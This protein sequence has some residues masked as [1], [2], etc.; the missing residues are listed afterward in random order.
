MNDV[1]DGACDTVEGVSGDI[2][3]DEPLDLLR[4]STPGDS[5][6]NIS[7]QVKEADV[8][9]SPDVMIIAVVNPKKDYEKLDA[10]NIIKNLELDV[11]N[12]NKL[13][14]ERDLKLKEL[15]R[16]KVEVANVGKLKFD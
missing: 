2:V 12:A 3:V 8:V 16:Q 11:A 13:L 15:E 9:V 4:L 6:G 7:V 5:L 10:Y 14:A 1:V